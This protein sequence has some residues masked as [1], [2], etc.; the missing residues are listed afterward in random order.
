M[1]G[2]A[3]WDA[4]ERAM[5]LVRDR[6]GKK[7]I[8]YGRVGHTWL[9]GSELKALRAHPAFR[10]ELDRQ[11]LSLYLSY[12]Y[13]PSPWSIYRGIFKLPPAHAITFRE[14]G[15]CRPRRYWAPPAAS[16]LGCGE[17]VTL[18]DHEAISQLDQRLRAAV[19]KRMVSDVPLGAFLSGG[20]DSSAIV[21]QMQAAA[22]RPVKTFTM[23]FQV[24]GYNEAEDAKAVAAHLGT[25]HTEF[26]VTP[27]EAR[28][29]IP[30]LPA[31]Y[32]EPFAD[33][34]QIPTY[35][36]SALARQKVTV[37]LSGDGGDELFAGYNRYRWGSSI[38]RRTG[39]I[40]LPLR[41]VLAWSLQALPPQHWDTLA[42]TLGPLG[43]RNMQVRLPGDKMHKLAGVL[44]AS[45]PRDLYRRLVSAWP[46][47]RLLLEN[48]SEP[49][50]M[51]QPWPGSNDG[52]V[53]QMMN[54]DLV[55]YLPDD[56]LTK[57]D[58]ASMAVSL[59]VRAP[60]LDYELIEWTAQLPARFRLRGG[61]GKWLLRQ[62]LYRYLPPALVNRPKSGFGVPIDHWLRGPLRDWAEDLLAENRLA[63]DGI[64]RPFPIREA[65]RRH[66]TGVRNEHSRLWPILMFQ[67]WRDYYNV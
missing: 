50:M 65:W 19:T 16:A 28:A 37:A 12:S 51:G 61:A 25:D 66:L 10:P 22:G 46:D 5:T 47:S 8:Y 57:V 23:G 20:I 41:R 55:T 45:D 15:E 1:F 9:F 42:R 11:A 48:A 64:L 2:I 58:R 62:V 32:D 44:G 33:S 53:E 4:A 13:V 56:I 18:S 54:R 35:L 60:L 7:P 17:A 59:E 36:V 34:S 52:F 49:D 43:P 67:A 6:L 30:R 14:E 26:Y 3:L 63:R 29:V 24:S 27:E 21:A 31:I 38:W 39:W 40:P